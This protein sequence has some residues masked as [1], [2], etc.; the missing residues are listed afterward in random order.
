VWREELFID[1][2]ER[3]SLEDGWGNIPAFALKS[4]TRGEWFHTSV[5]KGGGPS[6]KPRNGKTIT[7]VKKP[8]QGRTRIQNKTLQKAEFLEK[9]GKAIVGSQVK[10]SFAGTGGPREKRAGFEK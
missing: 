1:E 6:T 4:W 3:G 10:G 5:R 2:K 7:S 8:K 9:E